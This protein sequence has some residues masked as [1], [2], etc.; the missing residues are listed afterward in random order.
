MLFRSVLIAGVNYFRNVTS[1]VPLGAVDECGGVP[2]ATDAEF[3]NYKV[4]MTNADGSTTSHT[5]AEHIGFGHNGSNAT[6][7]ERLM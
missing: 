7:N 5:L 2:R 4:M 6:A 1:A 3:G